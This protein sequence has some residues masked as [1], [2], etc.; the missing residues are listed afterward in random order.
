MRLIEFFD[1]VEAHPAL[2]GGGLASAV[3]R[4]APAPISLTHH[5]EKDNFRWRLLWEE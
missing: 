1:R 4:A 3:D 5:L 2:E